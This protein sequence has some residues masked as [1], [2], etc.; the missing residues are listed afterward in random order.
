MYKNV[1]ACVKKLRNYD[2]PTDRRDGPPTDGQ[3]DEH[4]N[5]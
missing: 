3:I 4:K 1:K 2:R 5:S